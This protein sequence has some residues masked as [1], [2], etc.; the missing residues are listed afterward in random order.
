MY[1]MLPYL[2]Q[3]QC[4]ESHHV[5]GSQDS[6]S[7]H[8]SCQVQVLKQV[9]QHFEV[10][11]SL[12]LTCSPVKMMV[13]QVRNLQTSRIPY[14]QGQ[15]VSFREGICFQSSQNLLL[16]KYTALLKIMY[17]SI[18]I[19]IALKFFTWSFEKRLELAPLQ[20]TNSALQG[21]FS[22]R[23]HGHCHSGT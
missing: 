16:Q 21:Q 9:G 23:V 7:W 18:Y 14:F 12:K 22:L 11:P 10:V 5:S 1:H 20:W 17:Y 4:M 19:Y 6:L 15:A 2:L 8:D 13:F 3:I